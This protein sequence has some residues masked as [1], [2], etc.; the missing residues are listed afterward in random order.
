MKLGVR[1]FLACVAISLGAAPAVSFADWHY[2]RVTLLAFGYDGTTVVFGIE[3]WNRNDC[4]CYPTWPT[5]M[6]LDRTRQSFKEEFAWLLKARTVGQVIAVNIEEQSCKVIA[7]YE[8]GT[9]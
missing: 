4:T 5:Y 7:L 8:N 2:G 3:G 1:A 9:N 6:C